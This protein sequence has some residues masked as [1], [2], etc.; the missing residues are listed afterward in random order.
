MTLV[1]AD[2]ASRRADALDALDALDEAANDRLMM[3]GGIAAALRSR[4]SAAGV[5]LVV[6]IVAFEDDAF[7]A[8]RDACVG[9]LPRPA[10]RREEARL[11]EE[12]LRLLGRR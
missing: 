4:T 3:G 6:E 10:R 2:I 5:R 8:V 12:L 7:T 1:Q 11:A 9:Y